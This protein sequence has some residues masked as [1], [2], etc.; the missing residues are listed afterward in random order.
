MC[1]GIKIG[2]LLGI[3]NAGAYVYLPIP[4]QLAIAWFFTGLVEGIGAGIILGIVCKG[5]SGMCEA[6]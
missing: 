1:F 3:W 4:Q 6:K 2:L 5:K